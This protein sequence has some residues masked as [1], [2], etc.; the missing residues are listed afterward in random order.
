M[1]ISRRKLVGGLAA[2]SLASSYGADGAQACP[3]GFPAP[4]TTIPF[5]AVSHWLQPWRELCKTRS[6]AEIEGGIGIVIDGFTA[7]Q[8]ALEMLRQQGFRTARVEIR[9]GLVDPQTENRFIRQTDIEG[10]L[11]RLRQAGLRPLILLNAHDGNPCPCRRQDVQL[12][13]DAAAGARSIKLVSTAGLTPGRSGFERLAKLPAACPLV[14]AISGQQVSL[15]MQ[16]PAAI[17]AGTSLSFVTLSYEPFAEP[18]SAQNERTL[19]GWLRYVDLVCETAIS[20]LRSAEASDRGFDLEIWNEL[21]FGSRFLS[22]NNYYDPK[23]LD[24]NPR[25]L[26]SE[27]VQR[28]AAHVAEAGAKY[29]GIAIADGFSSTV[30][31]PASSS[32]PARVSALT[33]HPY[34][35]HLQFPASQKSSAVGLDTFGRKTDFIPDYKCYFPESLGNAIQTESICRDITDQPNEICG[36]AHGRF[37]RTED[38]T[39]SPVDVWITE[40]GCNPWA[41]GNLAAAVF[42]RQ[43]VA[44]SARSLFF[45][46]GIG[47][48]RVYLF[49]AF[50]TAGSFGLVDSAAPAVPS[51]ALRTI[52][53]ILSAVRGNE[54]SGARWATT[55]IAATAMRKAAD[56]HLFEGAGTPNLPPMT[57][58]DSLVLMPVQSSEQRIAIIY[59][60]MTRDIR[61][62][63]EPQRVSVAVRFADI[64][65]FTITYYDPISDKTLPAN[66]RPGIDDRVELEL[67]ATDI[68]KLVIFQAPP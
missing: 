22:I 65:N 15:S 48:A 13:E 68:P 44:F 20:A 1:K 51:V 17:P 23:I 38:G 28:T 53:R 24:Y 35:P 27:L 29:Q 3:A 67:A 58:A 12:A 25:L 18:G 62:P 10:F 43:I 40:I 19:A 8:D 33:K 16:L 32:E 57:A 39:V 42:D 59:Y 37:A 55:P 11:G 34:P 47:V 41:L 9:W 7:P 30:P 45:Y 26:W 54:K 2:G 5:G 14:T 56:L 52:A 6:L 63:L 49:E 36:V 31:W 61:M 60:I 66:N 4:I 46:L 64:A 50:G 21:T